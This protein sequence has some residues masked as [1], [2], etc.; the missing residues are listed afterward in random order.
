MLF[1][2]SYLRFCSQKF[3]LTDFHESIHLSNN[4]VQCK[5]KNSTDR[6]PALPSENMWDVATFKEYLK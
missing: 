1:R 2:E 4:A 5:Y 6:D 3:S